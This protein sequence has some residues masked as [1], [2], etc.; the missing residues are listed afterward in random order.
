[1]K[2]SSDWKRLS[3]SLKNQIFPQ[4]ART[5]RKSSWW[6]WTRNPARAGAARAFSAG[7]TR[8]SPRPSCPTTS[9]SPGTPT[10]PA[11]LSAAA[12]SASGR[13]WSSSAATASSTRS[14]MACCSGPTGR[15]AYGSCPSPSYPAAPATASPSPSP[16]PDSESLFFPPFFLISCGFRWNRAKVG[17]TLLFDFYTCWL[18]DK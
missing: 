7:S 18:I 15:S 6:S 1:M 13:A 12:S 8:S 3:A 2:L 10:T 16:S 5:R 17:V 4:P 9:S 14:S 11:T